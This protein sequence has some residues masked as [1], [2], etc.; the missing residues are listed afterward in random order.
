MLGGI[1]FII[2]RSVTVC[3]LKP[4]DRW[5]CGY[6]NGYDFGIQANTPRV[7]IREL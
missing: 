4:S 3:E 1:V 6:I 5:Q 2:W 7:T